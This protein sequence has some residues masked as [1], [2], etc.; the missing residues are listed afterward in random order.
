MEQLNDLTDQAWLELNQN[1]ARFKRRLARLLWFCYPF[2][3]LQAYLK[4][5]TWVTLGCLLGWS[6]VGQID[7]FADFM[8]WM[9][10]WAALL[11]FIAPAR[12]SKTQQCR[13]R[14]QQA[15]YPKLFDLFQ[16]INRHRGKPM[17]TVFLS[18]TA[19]ALA[20]HVPRFA[21]FGWRRPQLEIGL[22]ALLVLSPYQFQGMLAPAFA[23]LANPDDKT[24]TRALLILTQLSQFLAWI[25]HFTHPH[26]SQRLNSLFMQLVACELVLQHATV[27]AADR[28][29]SDWIG[30]NT[31][32]TGVTGSYLFYIWLNQHFWRPWLAMNRNYPGTG[33]TPFTDLHGFCSNYRFT[34]EELFSEAEHQLKV[35]PN[36]TTRRP[37][38]SQRLAA[39][40]IT[41]N[42]EIP[43]GP[44]AAEWS[45]GADLPSL[46]TAMDGKWRKTRGQ[47]ISPTQ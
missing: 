14:L 33:L 46:L 1:P 4:S 7:Y 36:I 10:L 19:Q 34:R 25:T 47:V 15:Q 18:D 43:V 31:T 13:I 17:P 22:Q 44:S 16:Q 28:R 35:T 2:I 30:K 21:F 27:F 5:L 23:H 12:Q 3:F 6:V 45:F 42:W 24:H 20:V 39:M 8:G 11:A 37:T 26:W 41:I 29:A 32:A 40:D 9:M 38:L